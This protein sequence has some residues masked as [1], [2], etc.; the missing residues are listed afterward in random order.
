[1]NQGITSPILTRRTKCP[2]PRAVPFVC[3]RCPSDLLREEHWRQRAFLEE[4]SAVDI[5]RVLRGD[6][7]RRHFRRR[8]RIR[9]LARSM[10]EGYLD[11]ARFA[12]ENRRA[13]RAHSGF[14]GYARVDARSL[15]AAAGDEQT[16]APTAKV[17]SRVGERG[18]QETLLRLPLKFK[19]GKL[20][21]S[22]EGVGISS[23]VVG[24]TEVDV[25]VRLR[26]YIDKPGGTLTR[27]ESPSWAKMRPWATQESS[28]LP[29][30][31]FE[32]GQSNLIVSSATGALTCDHRRS[33]N[34][35]RSVPC[36]LMPPVTLQLELISLQLA[37]DDS[38]QRH[39]GKQGDMLSSGGDTGLSGDS[40]HRS[41]SGKQAMGI[42]TDCLERRSEVSYCRVAWCGKVIGGTRAPQGGFPEPRWEGQ[43]FYLPLSASQICE[44]LPTKGHRQPPASKRDGD[45]LGRRTRD[46][47]GH[48]PLLEIT[49]G[50]LVAPRLRRTPSNHKEAAWSSFVN[51][52]RAP[53]LAG[54]VMLEAT[55]LLS[56]L[57]TQ[58]ARTQ[59]AT[60]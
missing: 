11:V 3:H 17:D 41:A 60:P 29:S 8:K 21:H 1:M 39:S 51:A 42:V 33:R 10:T 35:L 45:A 54:R 58:Q 2:G 26:K 25:R 19:G 18:I 40:S 38:A 6:R 44:T 12:G 16:L 14:L 28:E 47:E 56:M 20:A 52:K 55:D 5:Q 7:G 49:V 37:A 32:G 36:G 46:D 27:D 13:F 53:L 48:P 59:C 43:V 31:D 30:H 23:K 22:P 24:I 9:Q 34:I 15:L 57:G 50:R 4:R